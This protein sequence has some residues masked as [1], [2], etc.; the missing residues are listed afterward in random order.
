MIRAY[1]Y[2]DSH[3]SEMERNVFMDR[4]NTPLT[5]SYTFSFL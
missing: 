3:E 5:L 2:S 1:L 4:T